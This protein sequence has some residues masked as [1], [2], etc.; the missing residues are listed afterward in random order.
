[1]ITFLETT[2]VVILS[3]LTVKNQAVQKLMKF[4]ET[5]VQ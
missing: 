2:T 1:M 4:S 5:H 3:L